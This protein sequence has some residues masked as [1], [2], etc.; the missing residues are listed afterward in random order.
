M[1]ADCMFVIPALR[2]LRQGDYKFKKSLHWGERYCVAFMT[3]Y[4]FVII[5]FP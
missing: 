4:I 5:I 3:I 2:N 1:H